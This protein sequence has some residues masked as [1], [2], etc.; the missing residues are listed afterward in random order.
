[1]ANKTRKSELAGG[2]PAQTDVIEGAWTGR[3]RER[4]FARENTCEDCE[5]QFDELH[6]PFLLRCSLGH[7]PLVKMLQSRNGSHPT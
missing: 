2:V 6:F 5:A 4:D 3:E 1:M 7:C